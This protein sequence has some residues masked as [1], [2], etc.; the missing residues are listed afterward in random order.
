MKGDTFNS[1]AIFECI[2]ISLILLKAQKSINMEQSI[3]VSDWK[4]T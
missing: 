1:T 4:L 3:E 2:T